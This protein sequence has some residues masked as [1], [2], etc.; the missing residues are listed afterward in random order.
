MQ[1]DMQL[2]MRW[3][4]QQVNADLIAG[5]ACRLHPIYLNRQYFG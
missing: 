1:L 4:H 2:D 3:A 5:I